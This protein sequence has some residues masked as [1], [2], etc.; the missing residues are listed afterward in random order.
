MSCFKKTFFSRK[1]LLLQQNKNIFVTYGVKKYG[2][3]KIEIEKFVI[4]L[5]I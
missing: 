5:A 4:L 3:K 1:K 2:D